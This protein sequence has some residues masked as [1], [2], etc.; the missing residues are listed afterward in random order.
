MRAQALVNKSNCPINRTRKGPSAKKQIFREAPFDFSTDSDELR[1]LWD[2]DGA[3][4]AWHED[5]PGNSPDYVRRVQSEEE[6]FPVSRLP[7]R[8]AAP[9]K[10]ASFRY[11][12]DFSGPAEECA[13]ALKRVGKTK[14]DTLTII[15]AQ[16]GVAIAML[17]KAATKLKRGSRSSGT[18]ALFLKIFTVRPDF[19]PTWLKT[20]ATIKDRGDVVATRCKR[21]V[22]ERNAWVIATNPEYAQ[23]H[24]RT[25]MEFQ[26]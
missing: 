10:K 3:E 23:A 2:S 18:K 20:T 9:V 24:A 13:A 16:I 14:A 21:F 19:V 17:R 26:L 7:T 11:V 4:E 15:N 12:K 5:V 22:N 6:Q 1:E 8:G 25:I